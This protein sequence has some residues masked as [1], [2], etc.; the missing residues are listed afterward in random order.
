MI[1]ISN[2]IRF[3]QTLDEFTINLDNKYKT[4]GLED[5]YII[6][7]KVLNRINK[8]NFKDEILSFE[9]SDEMQN[10]LSDKISELLNTRIPY[11][12]GEGI[13]TIYFSGKEYEIDPRP[14]GHNDSDHLI[15]ELYDLY[16][17]IESCNIQNK[18]LYLSLTE[19]NN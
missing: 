10:I 15:K 2:T 19:T 1:L 16:N 5:M 6:P 12:K 3:N 9:E 18:P 7:K 14:T 13:Y 8:E 11:K 4:F 17:L